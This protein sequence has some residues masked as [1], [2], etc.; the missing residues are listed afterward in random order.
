MFYFCFCSCSYSQN[1]LFLFGLQHFEYDMSRYVFLIYIMLDISE[2][3]GSVVWC[4]ESS[5]PLLLQ[6][7]LLFLSILPLL[8][9]PSHI[10]Y[11]FYYCPT[12]LDVL[13]FLNFF[14]S[15]NFIF[16]SFYLPAFKPTNYF[17]IIVQSTDKSIKAFFISLIVLLISIFFLGVF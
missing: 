2:I 11:I 1:F 5:W 9:F 7:F 14:F 10:Y 15:L 12:V 16:G 13:F 3:T 4:L 6:I 8:V 17:L